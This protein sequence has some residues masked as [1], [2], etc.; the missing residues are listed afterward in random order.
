MEYKTENYEDK[1]LHIF[2]ET[3]ITEIIIERFK[4][5]L[6]DQNGDHKKLMRQATIRQ[7]KEAAIWIA[8]N[9]DNLGTIKEISRRVGLSTESLQNG[10]QQQ[11][12]S[13]VNHFIVDLKLNKAIELLDNSS[14]NISEIATELGISSRSYLSKIFKQKFGIGPTDYRKLQ[15]EG[16]LSDS[17]TSC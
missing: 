7:V 5:L 12:G 11:F 10:F 3:K 16:R 9:L 14:L 4:Q 2:R 15:V 1:M 6:D 17:N 13:S 8:D